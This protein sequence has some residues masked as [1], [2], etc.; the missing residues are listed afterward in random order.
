MTITNPNPLLDKVE[1][2]Y[3]QYLYLKDIQNVYLDIDSAYINI[4]S[5][6]SFSDLTLHIQVFRDKFFFFEIEEIPEKVLLVNLKE[7]PAGSELN[8]RI[9]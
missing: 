3:E 7:T 5:K 4:N 6:T 9:V 2:F 8:Y 1:T